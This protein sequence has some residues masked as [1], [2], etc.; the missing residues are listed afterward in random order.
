MIFVLLFSQIV[1]AQEIVSVTLRGSRTKAQI[2]SLFN[3]PLVKY[4]AKYYRVLYTS[5][6][7]K[8]SKD[9]LSALMVIPDRA[10]LT[11]PRLVYQHGT[12]DCKRCVPSNYGSTGGDEGQVGLLF[13]GLGFV[14]ILPDYVGMGNGRGF[15][16]YVHDA[17]TASASMDAITATGLWMNNNNIAVNNQMF[18]TG[19]SQGGY[20][21]MSLHRYLE[22]KANL[23]VTAAAHLSGPY[24]L[25]GA[26]RDLI[27]GDVPYQYP[28]YIPN[29]IL[30][31]QEVYGNIYNELSDVFK[32]EYISNIRAYYNGTITLSTLNRRIYATLSSGGGSPVAKKIFKDEFITAFSSDPNHPVNLILKENDLYDWSPTSPTRIFYCKADDQVPYQNSIIAYDK[33]IANG[34]TVLQIADINS[35]FDHTQCYNPALTSTVLFFLSLQQVTV[36]TNDISEDQNTLIYPNPGNDWVT[37]KTEKPWTKISFLNAQGQETYMQIYNDK[38]DVSSLSSGLYHVLIQDQSGNQV[39]TK[40][41]KY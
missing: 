21:S 15:Q 5:V 18:I 28:A 40:W 10:S 12:S 33:M 30:G 9:T 29:T 39:V 41:I 35:N 36:V 16:T 24:S 7:A 32:P 6:D 11:Y 1:L 8:G 34:T 26:M 38:I 22:T 4:G 14:S 17:T 25:S 20:A 2:T 27:L 37:I 19:Y 31:F 23:R 3:M 13:A